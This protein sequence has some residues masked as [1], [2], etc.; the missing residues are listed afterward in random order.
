MTEGRQRWGAALVAVALLAALAL[1]TLVTSR[2]AEE[3]S[4]EVRRI[5]SRISFQAGTVVAAE[6]SAGTGGFDSERVWSN[7]DDWEPAIAADRHSGYV[8]QLTTRYGGEGTCRRCPDP[9]L[10][11]RRSG[12]GGA[13]WERD[14]PLAVTAHPQNDPQIEVA[15]NGVI[16]AAWMDDYRPGIAFQRSL[17][18]GQ[19]WSA[20]LH[21][22]QRGRPPL[23][24]DRPILAASASGREVYIAFNAS[25]SYVSASHNFGQS[26][27]RAVRTSHDDR[28]WFHTAGAVA[29]DG[30]VYFAAVDYSQDYTGDSH[31]N[32]LKSA[33]G[34]RSWTTTR[35]D[36]SSQ[37]PDCSWSPGCYPG[38]FGPS[39]GLAV[40]SA[41]RLLVAYNAGDAPGAPQRLY[42]R[43]SPDGVHWSA[44]Q[45]VSS[46]DPLVNNAFP[47]LAAGPPPGD[48]RLVWQDDRN[49]STT[50]W[51]TWFRRTTNGGH[52]WSDPLRLSDLGSGAGY[53]TPQG[54][55]FP[56]GDY[57]EIAVDGTG[58]NH[59]IWGEGAGYEGPG[60]SWYT[61]GP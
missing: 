43:A 38:F 29:P 12:N 46:G 41:G 4:G 5:G 9:T 22:L 17:D 32:V 53:K 42:V 47:A 36:T 1:G 44:R 60:G 15:E 28:Y 52:T 11:F 49:G 19:H 51:N 16:Y 58:R 21:I 55:L 31:I 8:Y 24:S 7:Y 30:T 48:F 45:E 54:Y 56:Y 6:P 25:D 23:W 26:F 50:A 27:S 3:E 20:L 18:H 34:G 39:V 40:D 61:R 13:T 37:M 59:L 10:M 33:D 2:G 14:Q 35:A 57:L